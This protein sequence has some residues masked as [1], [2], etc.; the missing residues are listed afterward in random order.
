MSMY[1][2][3]KKNLSKLNRITAWCSISCCCHNLTTFAWSPLKLIER[4]LFCSPILL[5]PLWFY[6]VWS[7]CDQLGQ[8]LH[9]MMSLNI[10]IMWLL[11]KTLFSG[12]L[13][14]LISRFSPYH[15]LWT[16][17]PLP[18]LSRN[19]FI[20]SSV[21]YKHSVVHTLLWFEITFFRL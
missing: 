4:G 10:L 1:F 8:I 15:T 7:Y 3:K 9:G 6:F 19:I 18:F 2:E 14:T 21:Y 13:Q 11:L 12:A 5:F 16:I 17:G 20:L